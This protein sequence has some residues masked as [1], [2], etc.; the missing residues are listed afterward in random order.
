MKF[1][2]KLKLLRNEREYTLRQLSELTNLSISFISDVENGR[3][4]PSIENLNKIANGLDISVPEILDGTDLVGPPIK[5][6]NSQIYA[7]EILTDTVKVQESEAITTYI[8]IKQNRDE[9]AELLEILH[10]RPEMKALFSA[11]KNASK[12]DIERA[13]KIIEALKDE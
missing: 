6:G 3:R 11:S 13:I 4:K 8:S 12:E 9:A 1:G 7:N 2:E 10:K 5:T